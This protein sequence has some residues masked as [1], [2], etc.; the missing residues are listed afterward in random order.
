PGAKWCCSSGPSTA[1]LTAEIPVKYIKRLT[2][3]AIADRIDQSGLVTVGDLALGNPDPEGRVIHRDGVQ[4]KLRDITLY[5]QGRREDAVAEIV[6]GVGKG[7]QALANG[8]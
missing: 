4:R 3:G 1:A 8:A 6:L 7:Q 2:E 5:R